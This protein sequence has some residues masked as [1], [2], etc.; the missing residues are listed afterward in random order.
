MLLHHGFQV[1]SADSCSQ[2]CDKCHQN[3]NDY[4]LVITDYTMPKSNG[5]ELA[6]QLRSSGY[7]GLILLMT[8]NNVGLDMDELRACGI[9]SIVLK[10][11]TI[12]ELIN[13]VYQAISLP[14]K[15]MSV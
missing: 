15:E 1:D 13:H 5:L 7:I 4:D 10:P 12:N 3:S 9:H 2:A 11:M 14:A 6:R 8:G